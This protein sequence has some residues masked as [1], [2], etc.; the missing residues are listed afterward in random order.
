[1][2]ETGLVNYDAARHALA[3]CVRIDD[4]KNISDKA[5]AFKNICTSTKKY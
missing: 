2:T 3:M 4:A 1:M 5:G